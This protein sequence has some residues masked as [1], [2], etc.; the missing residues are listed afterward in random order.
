L[1]KGVSFSSLIEEALSW[2]DQKFSLHS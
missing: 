1:I 2:F